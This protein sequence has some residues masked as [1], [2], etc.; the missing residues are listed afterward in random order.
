M[1]VLHV[2]SG[3]LYGGVETYLVTLARL[4]DIC[5]AMEPEFALCFAGRLSQE[6]Q[7]HNAQVHSLGEVRSR[8][9]WTVARARRTLKKLLRQESYDVVV[10]HSAWAQAIFGPVVHRAGGTIKIPLVFYLHNAAEKR[11]W[12]ERWAARVV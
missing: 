11:H 1:R 5:P 6:L 7:A 10:C 8:F 2:G 9:P 3:N 4:R 12:L